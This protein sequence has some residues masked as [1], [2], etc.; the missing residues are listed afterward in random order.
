MIARWIGIDCPTKPC[1]ATYCVQADGKLEDVQASAKVKGYDI[2][3]IKD[4][5]PLAILGYRMFPKIKLSNRSLS[6][7][8]VCGVLVVISFGPDGD[9]Y[10]MF[11]FRNLWIDIRKPGF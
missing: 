11:V 2:G 9:H 6:L 5:S 3:S 8:N 7:Q 10:K 1:L 4:Y